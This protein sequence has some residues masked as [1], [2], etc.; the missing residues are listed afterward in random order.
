MSTEELQDF[1]KKV[2]SVLE[3]AKLAFGVIAS[4]VVAVFCLALWVN[5]KANAIDVNTAAMASFQLESRETARWRATK[6][7]ID[8]RFAVILENQQ[9]IIDRVQSTEDKLVD[10]IDRLEHK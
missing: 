9:K 6:D 4:L 7:E 1:A 8:I 5:N 3:F 2:S 10:R